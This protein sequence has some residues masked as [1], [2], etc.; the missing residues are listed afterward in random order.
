M[1]N[2]RA[3]ADAIG[4]TSWGWKL[5]YQISPGA[6]YQSDRSRISRV[7]VSMLCC[8]SRTTTAVFNPEL[9]FDT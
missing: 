8:H 7:R 1:Y 9:R 4:A 6:F 2:L 3:I 5:L